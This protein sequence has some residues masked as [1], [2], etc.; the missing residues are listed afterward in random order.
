MSDEPGTLVDARGLRCPLP[1]IRLAAAA[2]DHAPGDVLTV[3]STDPAARHDV[4]AW[5]RMRGHTVV[6]SVVVDVPDAA[7]DDGTTW[8]VTVRLGG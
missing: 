6:E 8:A 4:P 5:A 2:R 3:W 7:P 1:V